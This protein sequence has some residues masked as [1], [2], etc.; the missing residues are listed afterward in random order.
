MTGDDDLSY[1]EELLNPRFGRRRGTEGPRGRTFS[2]ELSSAL[3]RYGGGGLGKGRARQ[4]RGRIAVREPRA[5]SRRC[6]I[7][8]RYVPITA[9]GQ[10]GARLHLAYLERDGVAPDG[11]PGRLYGELE[12]IS[13]EAFGAP[14][15]GERRQF[16]FIVSPEDGHRLD[17]TEFTRQFM[18]QVE[19]DT[20]RRLIWAAVNHHNTDNPHVHIVIR[21][22]DRDGDDLRIDGRYIGREMRWRA[23]EIATR[24]LGLRSELEISAGRVA[25]VRR[26]RFTEIDRMLAGHLSPDGTV[27][28]PKLLAAPGPE[29]RVC[30]A[31]LQTLERMGLASRQSAAVWS[32]KDG[33]R[34]ILGQLGEGLDASERLR[35]LV[36][37][38]G[39]RYH[40]VDR[41]S[42]VPVFEA[43]VAGKGLHD[44][45][46]GEMFA[47]VVTAPGD[48]YYVR[49]PP[50]AAESLHAGDAVRVGFEVQP[51]LKPADRIIARYAQEHGGIYDPPDHQRAL[52]ALHRPSPEAGQP[53]P[54]GRV[55]AN[56]RRLER[57]ARYR[58]A[59]RL[60][61]GRWQVNSDL[62]SQL[63][64]RE[65]THPQ[66]RFRI[67]RVVATPA[68]ETPR[69]LANDTTKELA[70]L[71][72]QL[73][74]QL[75]LAYVSEPPA[76]KGR[77]WICPPARSGREYVAIIDEGARQFTLLAKPAGAE[78]M[79]RRRVR[80]V[81]NREQRLSID[82]GPEVSR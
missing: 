6:V 75:G 51:W 8:A 72:Q 74:K 38:Q 81:R 64:A 31:R 24:E 34:G 1:L 62:L 7:K 54:A 69:A 49:L 43:V 37:D 52:E 28:L 55:A 15:D 60:P 20:G 65:R 35:A 61:D 44:E 30:L 80:V 5:Q 16:R 23:Q 19:K 78:R 42:P 21:G 46:T 73:T 10:K 25:D 26:E 41:E 11:S 48:A 76:F 59:E 40:I 27:A 18:K 53:S 63:E 82:L 77:L 71:G 29:G 66:H 33:W 67:E 22:V 58:L 2:G 47:A 68:R 70:A 3:R 57:L 56:I 14:L 79:Q 45:L 50:D 13:A 36:P 12:E 39:V 9:S 17:L 4:Q 32:L